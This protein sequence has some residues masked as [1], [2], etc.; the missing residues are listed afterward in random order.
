VT[1]PWWVVL[2]GLELP[3]VLGLLDCWQRGPDHFT[4]GADD[5]RAF[6]RRNAP[7]RR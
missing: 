6:V 2:L 5:R 7:A 3:V 1:P 4:E